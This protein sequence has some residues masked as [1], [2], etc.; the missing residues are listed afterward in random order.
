M[1]ISLRQFATEDLQTYKNWRDLIDARQ[2]MSRFYPRAFGGGEVENPG[3]YEWYMIA[4]DGVDVGTIWLEKEKPHST[5]VTLGIIIGA[6]DRLGI[7]IGRKTIPLAIKQ[8][9]T[10]L[11]FEAVRLNVRKINARA[12]AC[13]KY[14][15]F[16]V[17]NEGNKTNPAGKAIPFLEMQLFLVRDSAEGSEV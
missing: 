7:G 6:Q 5:V 15:G 13:Y 10:T 1:D 17:V 16:Q 9:R 4:A 14:C 8:A 3:I 11:G 12:I 2:Y